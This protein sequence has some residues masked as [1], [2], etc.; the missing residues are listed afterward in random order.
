MAGEEREDL[1]DGLSGLPFASR[2]GLDPEREMEFFGDLK[3]LEG[4]GDGGKVGKGNCEVSVL[5]AEDSE[6]VDVG[7]GISE[8]GGDEASITTLTTD[9]GSLGLSESLLSSAAAPS[10][11]GGGLVLRLRT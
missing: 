11:E 8:T 5:S 7:N 3:E 10:L 1:R 4:C 9:S 2:T 6:I